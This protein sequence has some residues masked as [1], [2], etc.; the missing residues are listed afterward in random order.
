MWCST[1]YH[2]MFR[3]LAGF[4]LHFGVASWHQDLVWCPSTERQY[5]DRV[6]Q[7]KNVCFPLHRIV[8]SCFNQKMMME[9]T[10]FSCPPYCKIMFS[11]IV[12]A[13][14]TLHRDMNCCKL[15]TRWKGLRVF[16][17]MCDLELGIGWTIFLGSFKAPNV[18]Y[19]C[20]LWNA[21]KMNRILKRSF[22]HPL[23]IL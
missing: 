18:G 5:Q 21:Q 3:C 12:P 15:P 13:G 14:E 16:C 20:V 11:F 7:S 9:Q 19:V 8:E 23:T 2:I 6:W 4:C 22:N 17:A 1:R 10:H